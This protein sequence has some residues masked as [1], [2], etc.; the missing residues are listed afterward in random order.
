MRALCGAVLLDSQTGT[1]FVIRKLRQLSDRK[2]I[3]DALNILL[4]DKKCQKKTNL[5]VRKLC[6]VRQGSSIE[7]L[8]VFLGRTMNSCR[9]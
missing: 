6:R 9:T 7:Q 4:D 1:R 3:Y 8:S 5:L 2:V